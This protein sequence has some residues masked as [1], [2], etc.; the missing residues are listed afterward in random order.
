[1]T[2]HVRFER[3]RAFDVTV[4]DLQRQV[5]RRVPGNSAAVG[6]EPRPVEI[7]AILVRF[8]AGENAA[9]QFQGAPLH[10]GCR[11]AKRDV[12]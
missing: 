4:R 10:S 11:D 3:F 1:M 6:I 5:F 2:L 9:F 8:A 12:R 7:I